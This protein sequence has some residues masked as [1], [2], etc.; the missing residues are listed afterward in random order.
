MA[1]EIG[2]LRALLSL[3]SAAFDKGAKRAK[4]S[5]NGLQ[6]S[7]TNASEKLRKT[8]RQLTTRVT[9]PLVGIGTAAVA[10]SAQ[11]IDAQAKMAESFDTTVV[12][13]QNLAR[14]SELAGISQEDLNGSL[15][16][17]VRR[18]SLAEQGTGAAKDALAQLELSA[19]DLADLPLDERVNKITTA[20][21]EMIPEAEQAGV[22]SKVFGDRTGLAM[23]RLNPDVIARATEEVQRFGVAT[24]EVD[25]DKVQSAGD[26]MSGLKLVAQGLANQF[27]SALAPTLQSIAETLSQVGAAFSG[28]S[29]RTKK[30]TVAIA[31]LTAVAGPLA[32][33]LGV[34]A[35]GLAALASPIGIVVAGLTGIAA[36]VGVVVAKWDEIV[37]AVPMLGVAAERVGDTLSAAWEGIKGQVTALVEVVSGA[38]NGVVAL[39]EGDIPAAVEGFKRAFSGLDAFVQANVDMWLGIFDGLLPGVRDAL[40][41]VAAEVQAFF[42]ELPG[43]M[44]SI[45]RDIIDGLKEGLFQRWD[46]LK[47]T[48]AGLASDL[49]GWIKGP[50]GIESPSRVFMEIGRNIMEGLGLGISENT[51]KAKR[52]VEGAADGMT[53][54]MDGFGDGAERAGQKFADM[55]KGLIDGS[56]SIGDVAEQLRSRLLSTGLD[57]LFGALFKQTGFGDIFAGL[58]DSGGRIPSGKF[59]IVGERGPEF[60]SGPASVTSRAATA[61][62]I[63][64]GGTVV[65]VINNTGQPTQQEKSRTPDGRELVRTI[66]GEDMASGRFD[67]PMQ[68]RFGQQPQRVRR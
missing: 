52:A 47:D 19:K 21:R 34:V 63:G 48:V 57:N 35:A 66:V 20:I 55:A 58:F 30:I 1:I 61:R 31:G 23:L 25:A 67:G 26:A 16:R 13:M 50:L 29:P 62:A 12:S 60:V 46:S 10:T 56:R 43:K 2:A 3:D 22:A 11:T 38:V 49:P 39:F 51:G 33:T 24:S 15:R 14:A 53:E 36:V 68:S 45:G 7:L 42:S 64:S 9:L 28:L 4:A 65:Q 44:T 6:R 27:T 37:E 54:S 5:M 59:G 17:M 41:E 8:G 18:V 40:A 32:V